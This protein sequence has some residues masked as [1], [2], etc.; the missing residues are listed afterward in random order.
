[1]IA[2]AAD[3][4]QDNKIECR[5]FLQYAAGVVL[6]VGCCVVWYCITRPGAACNVDAI[7]TRVRVRMRCYYTQ[8]GED[9][10]DFRPSAGEVWRLAPPATYI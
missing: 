10:G 4:N 1:M 8:D 2:K 3:V 7:R 6:G 5:E 9:L